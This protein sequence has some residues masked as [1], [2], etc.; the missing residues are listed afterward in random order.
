MDPMPGRRLLTAK[1][2]SS[3]NYPISGNDAKNLTCPYLKTPRFP[4]LPAKLA[5]GFRVTRSRFYVRQVHRHRAS[6]SF[7]GV[8]LFAIL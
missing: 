8:P 4:K 2:F 1:R 5:L 3:S 7:P 6:L